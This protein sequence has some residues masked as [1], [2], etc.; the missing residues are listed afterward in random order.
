MRVGL[1]AVVMLAAP[2]TAAAQLEPITGDFTIA[3]PDVSDADVIRWASREVGR[4]DGRSVGRRP[5]EPPDPYLGH[6][7]APPDVM[8]AGD[9][10]RDVGRLL[11][12]LGGGLLGAVV[13]G[14]AGTAIIWAAFEENLTG[15]WLVLAVGAGT[16]LGALSVTAG[17]TLAA[18]L[19]GGRGNFGHAFLGQILGGAAALPFVVLA[20]DQDE[21]AAALVAAGLLPLVGA[22]L[23]YEIGHANGGGTLPVIVG[24]APVRGGALASLT[25]PI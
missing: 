14:G 3:D 1:F 24:V 23:G 4:A 5:P 22:I 8:L 19:T 17:V 15:D 2:A 7:D 12:E 6:D 20:L 25:T 11:G 10:N 21:L 16:V 9:V 13:G 18:H